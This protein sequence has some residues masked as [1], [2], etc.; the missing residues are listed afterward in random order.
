M[1]LA[2]ERLSQEK[3][4]EIIELWE[5]YNTR[6]EESSSQNLDQLDDSGFDSP[7]FSPPSSHSSP[8]ETPVSDFR[9]NSNYIECNASEN[10]DHAGM[11]RDTVENTDAS[12][13]NDGVENNNCMEI[14]VES[15]PA[16]AVR[17]AL[18]RDDAGV[19]SETA[20]NGAL[21]K[22]RELSNAT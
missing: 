2:M 4:D 13:E 14:E 17:E 21:E 16:G 1:L 20:E 3:K 15:D 5:G 6:T 11:E 12:V 18:E 9:S 19:M 10:F 8:D 7:S 22:L